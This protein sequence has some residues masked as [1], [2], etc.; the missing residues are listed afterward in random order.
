MPKRRV[1]TAAQIAASKRNLEKARNAKR[2][3]PR[4]IENK[5]SAE[6]RAN[7]AK[8]G[9]ISKV[10]AIMYHGKN[11]RLYHHT[12]EKAAAQIIKTQTLR[13]R[14]GNAAKG[15]P[16]LTEKVYFSRKKRGLASDF[17]NAVVS[18]S[19]NHRKAKDLGAAINLRMSSIDKT[20][21]Y[22]VVKRKDLQGIKIRRE[23]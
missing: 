9:K 18:V 11:I 20:D 3:L 6:G 21:K 13:G 4:A 15:I 16:N 10:P 5:L 22:Y 23:L 8:T 7:F 1:R 19:I 2:K 12:N 17:G 14:K